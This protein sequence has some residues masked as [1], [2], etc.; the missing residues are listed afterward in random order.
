M[1]V[2]LRAYLRDGQGAAPFDEAGVAAAPATSGVY[3]LYREHRVLYIGVAV[4]GTGIRQEL[5]K[6]LS[7]AY[8]ARTRTA[9][10]FDFEQT[11]DPVVARGEYL[12]AHRAQYGGRLPRY[13]KTESR[14]FQGDQP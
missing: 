6:H 10:A 5:E 4:H 11:R 1:R 7:G 2:D 12:A 8:G 9:T 3:F 13:N 14:I